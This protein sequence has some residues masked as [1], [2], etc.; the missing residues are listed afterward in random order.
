M[1]E[2]GEFSP[3]C[4][5]FLTYAQPA[6]LH[7]TAVEQAILEF[8]MAHPQATFA[9]LAA[10]VPG[11]NG[12]FAVGSAVFPSVILWRRVSEAAVKALWA[13]ERERRIRFEPAD[14]QVYAEHAARIALPIAPRLKDYESPHW[15]PVMVCA[16]ARRK[17][18]SPRSRIAST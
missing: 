7:D 1:Q 2:T 12:D 17:Q 16:A 3:N 11:F 15:Y 9:D 4:L 8:L 13:L 6:A 14:P 5:E 18:S 10:G